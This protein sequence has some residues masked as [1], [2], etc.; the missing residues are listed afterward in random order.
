MDGGAGGAAGIAVQEEKTTECMR[1]SPAYI[2]PARP[3]RRRPWCVKGASEPGSRATSSPQEQE[4]DDE[5][6]SSWQHTGLET[7]FYML[8]AGVPKRGGRH[9]MNIDNNAFN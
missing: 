6:N 9:T 2:V 8:L 7:A 1:V 4:T 3:Q 5:E